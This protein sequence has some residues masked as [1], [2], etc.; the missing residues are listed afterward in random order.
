[1]QWIKRKNR[2]QVSHRFIFISI[3]FFLFEFYF[4]LDFWF[5]NFYQH[6]YSKSA[7]HFFLMSWLI[8]LGQ[9]FTRIYD[10]DVALF[11]ILTSFRTLIYIVLYTGNIVYTYMRYECQQEKYKKALEQQQA[12]S[13]NPIQNAINVIYIYKYML[14]AYVVYIEAK[15]IFHFAFNL[16]DQT[17]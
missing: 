15:R 9:L 6:R 8:C 4:S 11:N 14:Y 7:I 3:D 12:N 17:C 2:V 1:M 16:L 5:L 13:K 10:T